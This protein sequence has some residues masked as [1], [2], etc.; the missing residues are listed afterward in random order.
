[1]SLFNNVDKKLYKLGFEK[2]SENKHGVYY[3]RQ[4]P[5]GFNHVI[6]ILRKY[7]GKLH[8]QSYQDTT[9]S[10]GYNN[11]VSM[12]PEVAKLVLAKIKHMKF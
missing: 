12:T 11:M 5:L 8:I 7:N 1:M 9:N 10:D 6:A 4:D 2:T 3:W